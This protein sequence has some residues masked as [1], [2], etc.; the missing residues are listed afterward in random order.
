MR[1]PLQH[2]PK[3]EARAALL[4][5]VVGIS[6]MSIKF[7]AYG[8]TQSAAI[9]SDAVESIANVLASGVAM[10]SL[11]VA[12]RPAD[13]EHPYGHGKVEFLSAWFEGGMILMAAVFIF[14][15]TLDAM[16]HRAYLHPEGADMGLILVGAAMVVNGG[17]GM[18]LL[19]TGRKQKSMTLEAD[20]KH[21]MSDAYTS[22]A[23]LASLAIVKLT[24]WRLADPITALLMA[25]YIAWMASSLL[26]RASA[27]L[28]DKQD[29]EDERVIREILDSHR[30]PGGKEPRICSYHKLRHRHSGR[31]MW[32]DFHIMVPADLKVDQAH[33]QASAIEYEIEQR[34]G[35][36][37]ATAHIEPCPEPDCAMRQVQPN[38]YA[39]SRPP[40]LASD[41]K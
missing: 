18:Y 20:G 41:G 32:V 6:L 13:E 22:V 35:E 5:L 11:M 10:Y 30:G 14:I 36:G 27:G 37:N 8:L 40:L 1:G 15:R 31:Y 34:M 26:R 3:A 39:T 29:I 4:S 17:V 12:H 24:G 19:H 38:L 33:Q 2:I 7:V 25:C 16:M 23:V 21:L 28:M 9:F